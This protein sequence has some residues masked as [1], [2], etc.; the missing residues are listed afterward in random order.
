M[1][2]AG[3]RFRRILQRGGPRRARRRCRESRRGQPPLQVPEVEHLSEPTATLLVFVVPLE[4]F[5]RGGLRQSQVAVVLAERGA[6]R[7]HIYVFIVH[8][9]LVREW[10]H[11]SV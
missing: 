2:G 10:F 5:F 7:I 3:R 4:F 6:G 1:A 9:P 11:S 8:L